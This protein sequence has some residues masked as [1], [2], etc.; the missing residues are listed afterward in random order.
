MQ[1]IHHLPVQLS[2]LG[3]NS[4][5]HPI[6]PAEQPHNSEP[7]PGAQFR[8]WEIKSH[9][10]TWVFNLEGLEY[11]DVHLPRHGAGGTCVVVCWLF[12]AGVQEGRGERENAMFA[13]GKER[14][15][16]SVAELEGERFEVAYDVCRGRIARRYGG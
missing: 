7:P 12:A 13:S 16:H 4:I 11:V 8:D 15:G 2:T 6:R 9:V 14:V 1:F 3:S 10:P 5:A